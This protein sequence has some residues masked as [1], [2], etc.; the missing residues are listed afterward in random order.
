MFLAYF[1]YWLKVRGGGCVT[2]TERRRVRVQLWANTAVPAHLTNHF[3]WQQ[4]WARRKKFTYTQ[5]TV[6]SVTTEDL[7]VLNIKAVNVFLLWSN[8]T[9]LSILMGDV[10]MRQKSVWG[11]IRSKTLQ[12]KRVDPSLMWKQLLL[13]SASAYT[14]LILK[15]F[16]FFKLSMMQ[17]MCWGWMRSDPA[18][19]AERVLAARGAACVWTSRK[20]CVGS[21]EIKHLWSYYQ[22]SWYLTIMVFEPIKSSL[23][24][25]SAVFING[26]LIT[27]II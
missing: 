15:H 10:E 3:L 8:R 2:S 25:G 11:H 18:C 4:S 23:M 14:Y 24:S 21:L 26:F 13:L 9:W 22:R 6:H 1:L 19:P 5:L 16:G 12:V 20:V 7:L 17:I 27:H